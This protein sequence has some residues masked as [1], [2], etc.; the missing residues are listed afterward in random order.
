MTLF[1]VSIA[2]EISER[3]SFHQTTK[4]AIIFLKNQELPQDFVYRPTSTQ[5]E[6]PIGG[7]KSTKIRTFCQDMHRV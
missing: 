2:K 5:F 1:A 4:Y 3:Y 7:S 6:D